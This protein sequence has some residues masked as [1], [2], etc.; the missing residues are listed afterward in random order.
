MRSLLI[1]C[2]IINMKIE[3][4]AFFV[5]MVV[6]IKRVAGNIGCALNTLCSRN[7]QQDFARG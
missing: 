4:D 6:F 1:R 7:Q 5:Y 2:N 3:F